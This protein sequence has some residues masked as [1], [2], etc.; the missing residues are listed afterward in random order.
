MDKIKTTKNIIT[1]G[2][3]KYYNFTY[4]EKNKKSF[5]KAE[6]IVVN[7]VSYYLPI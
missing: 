3:K 2:G 5:D 4:M 1:I 7:K 6:F